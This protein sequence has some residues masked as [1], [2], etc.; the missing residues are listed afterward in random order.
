MRQIK[1]RTTIIL[2]INQSRWGAATR[3]LLGYYKGS[4]RTHLL[5]ADIIRPSNTIWQ[6][7]II[8][9]LSDIIRQR[10]HPTS[11]HPTSDKTD[12]IRQNWHHPW[13]N[14]TRSDDIGWCQCPLLGG[15]SFM[16]FVTNCLWVF[17]VHS[18]LTSLMISSI[19]SLLNI[20]KLSAGVTVANSTLVELSFSSMTC[21]RI[22]RACTHPSFNV[23]DLW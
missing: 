3:S 17:W 16:K 23:I 5:R 11:W 21:L 6:S 18:Y 7:N 12:I 9:Q 22:V 20:L 10:H 4:W 15:S 13:H 8:Q 1:S 14:P 19:S 2:R